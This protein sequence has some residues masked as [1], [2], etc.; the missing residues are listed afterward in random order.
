[1]GTNFLGGT[2]NVCLRG[3]LI[4]YY[5]SRV[6]L[7]PH[8]VKSPRLSEESNKSKLKMELDSFRKLERLNL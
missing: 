6:W 8:P 4:M 7:I 1:M 3:E 2:N 5:S